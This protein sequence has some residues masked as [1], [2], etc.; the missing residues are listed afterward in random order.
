V[1]HKR[2]TFQ[3]HLI[4]CISGLLFSS[5]FVEVSDLILFSFSI[6]TDDFY[7]SIEGSCDHLDQ[8]TIP[9]QYLLEGIASVEDTWMVAWIAWIQAGRTNG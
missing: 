1:R 6:H 8:N 5:V 4:I 3:R 9:A 7:L 2:F